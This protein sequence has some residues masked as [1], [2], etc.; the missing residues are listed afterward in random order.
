MRELLIAKPVAMASGLLYLVGFALLFP[1][2]VIADDFDRGNRAYVTAEFAEAFRIWLPLAEAGD[3]RAQF[4]IAS[5]YDHGQGVEVNYFLSANWFQRSA[6]QGLAVAQFNLGN[7]FRHGRGVPQDDGEAVRLW[8]L[9][10]QQGL[11]SAQYNLG[12]Q[13]LSGLG[14]K[15][16]QVEAR[17]WYQR[18][19][20]S[21]HPGAIRSLAWLDNSAARTAASVPGETLSAETP[22][23]VQSPPSNPQA[24]VADTSSSLS[25]IQVYTADWLLEQNPEHLTLQLAV[26]SEEARVLLFIGK[27]EVSGLLSYFPIQRGGR[28][29][30]VLTSGIF[31][32][33]PAALR[34]ME[35]LPKTVQN[36]RPWIRRLGA[37]QEQIRASNPG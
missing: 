8:R 14:V 20:N 7:A 9:A 12:T 37:I 5:L 1:I 25:G 28:T 32:D 35:D 11:P 6:R 36:A 13:Y 31:T 16:D 27:H 3:P 4:G 22:A 33:R 30:F 18:A 15:Q 19:A 21:G 2:G 23:T 26:M 17:R 29:L 24:V 34:S 10:A